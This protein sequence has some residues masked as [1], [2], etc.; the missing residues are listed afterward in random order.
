MGTRLRD[1]FYL[2]RVIEF[3]DDPKLNPAAPE[4]ASGEGCKSR[5]NWAKSFRPT[6]SRFHVLSDGLS[7][8]VFRNWHLGDV[9]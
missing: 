7:G 5:A 4:Q 3:N 1:R 2:G 8:P 6:I 9:L